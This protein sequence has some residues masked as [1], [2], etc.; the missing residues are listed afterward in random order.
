MP[1]PL[2]RKVGHISCANPGF[3]AIVQCTSAPE[4]AHW[5]PCKPRLLSTGSPLA[6][7]L[8]HGAF[9]V[10]LE[11]QV[12]RTGFCAFPPWPRPLRHSASVPGASGGAHDAIFCISKSASPAG[13]SHSVLLRSV[14]CG[15]ALCPLGRG[16]P[17]ES[18]L[19]VPH[20]PAGVPLRSS[21]STGLCM[22]LYPVARAEAPQRDS[23]GLGRHHALVSLG[24]DLER[25]CGILWM[26]RRVAAAVPRGSPAGSSDSLRCPGADGPLR[27]PRLVQARRRALLP[28]KPRA[29]QPVRT[30]IGPQSRGIFPRLSSGFLTPATGGRSMAA[31]GCSPLAAQGHIDIPP[32]HVRSPSR[33][34]GPGRT[35]R[36]P[37]PA[38]RRLPPPRPGHAQAR[39]LLSVTVQLDPLS[40]GRP[41]FAHRPQWGTSVLLS[42]SF[43][44]SS[45]RAANA[46]G[47]IVE[48]LRE[49]LCAPGRRVPTFGGPGCPG[50]GCA[51]ES[52]ADRHVPNPGSQR[53]R[54]PHEIETGKPDPG[55]VADPSLSRPATAG[56]ATPRAKRPAVRGERGRRRMQGAR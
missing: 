11:R 29:S 7:D 4:C 52:S 20:K 10:Q 22:D 25:L 38:L 16:R 26:P 43:S 34:P 55:P 33:R 32:P 54:N 13:S 28:R 53:R 19:P 5:P 48:R 42:E 15:N 36:S 50:Y 21:P 6:R 46:L 31:P 17:A 23:P 51:R 47:P 2:A 27:A 39:A 40:H 35:R 45:L 3:S 8:F 24:S 9:L 14:P 30:W 37:G 18:C 49:T 41:H 1:M 56:P 12:L 44:R